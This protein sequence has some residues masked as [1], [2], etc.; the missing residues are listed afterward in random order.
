[1]R[2]IAAAAPEVMRTESAGRFQD[3]RESFVELNRQAV[4]LDGRWIIVTISRD[5]T[6]RKRAETRGTALCAHVCRLERHQ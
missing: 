1:M 6:E 3:G 2:L 5:V 4:H